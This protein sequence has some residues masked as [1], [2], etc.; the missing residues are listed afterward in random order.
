MI[1]RLKRRLQ[2]VGAGN[3]PGK[4]YLA[5]SVA[6]LQKG[7]HRRLR[8]VEDEAGKILLCFARGEHLVEFILKAREIDSPVLFRYADLVVLIA[9]LR[10]LF[11]FLACGEGQTQFYPAAVDELTAGQIQ[12]LGAKAHLVSSFGFTHL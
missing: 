3:A 5:V 11:Q 6:K 12:C 10:K 4:Q 7:A 2:K 9:F 8:Y 1:L